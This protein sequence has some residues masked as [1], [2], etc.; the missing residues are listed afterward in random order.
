M[1]AAV[2]G[3]HIFCSVCNNAFLFDLSSG[4]SGGAMVLGK[5]EV[6]GRPTI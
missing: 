2:N 4:W 3:H 6:P 5:L 1:N